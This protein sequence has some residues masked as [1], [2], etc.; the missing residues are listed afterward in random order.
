ML[1][2][3]KAAG[4]RQCRAGVPPSSR[5][6][7]LLHLDGEKA[8][9]IVGVCV[10]VCVNIGS[11]PPTPTSAASVPAGQAHFLARKAP[12]TQLAP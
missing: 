10:C 4:G 5:Q 11:A 9:G 8:L 12:A 1:P 2:S 3:R 7:R 6:R